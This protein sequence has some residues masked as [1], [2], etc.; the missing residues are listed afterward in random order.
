MQN[1]ANVVHK[2]TVGDGKLSGNQPNL[3]KHGDKRVMCA[4][5]CE[6]C[7]TIHR[8]SPSGLMTQRTLQNSL[9]TGDGPPVQHLWCV[10]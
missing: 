5:V 8:K 7:R 2:R 3:G 4:F 1:S 10:L 9:S 6:C